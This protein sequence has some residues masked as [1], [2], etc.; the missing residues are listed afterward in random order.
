MVRV[1]W[2]KGR[3]KFIGVSSCAT[4]PL[5]CIKNYHNVHNSNGFIHTHN[6]YTKKNVIYFNMHHTSLVLSSAAAIWKKGKRKREAQCIILYS[7]CSNRI[8]RKKQRVACKKMEIRI[9]DNALE[10]KT[11]KNLQF[12]LGTQTNNFLPKQNKLKMKTCF[13]FC[14]HIS[15]TSSVAVMYATT[16]K[17]ASIFLCF[18]EYAKKRAAAVKPE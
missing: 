2:F 13:C 9:P 14:L 1:E 18:W 17:S 7:K 10:C 15:Q 11:Q 5:W 12:K 4:L 3:R 16:S 8:R 6:I